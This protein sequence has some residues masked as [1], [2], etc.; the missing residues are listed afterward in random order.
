[1]TGRSHEN[2]YTHKFILKKKKSHSVWKLQDQKTSSKTAARASDQH[3]LPLIR[4]SIQTF[5]RYLMGTYGTP[6]RFWE[7]ELL[8]V[9]QGA[10]SQGTYI[11]LLEG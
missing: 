11:L 9:R 8:Q 7:L 4:L 10:C 2:Q 5:T 1:M 3:H 6:N